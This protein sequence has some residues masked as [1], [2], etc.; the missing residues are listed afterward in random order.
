MN[1]LLGDVDHN[2]DSKIA[3]PSKYGDNEL[4]CGRFELSECSCYFIN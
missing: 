2:V 1:K 3:N 4:P